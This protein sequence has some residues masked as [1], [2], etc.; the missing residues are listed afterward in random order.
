[1]RRP[2]H[3]RSGGFSLTEVVL[4]LGIVSFALVAVVGL[5]PVGLQAVKNSHDQAAAA[6]VLSSLADSLRRAQNSNGAYTFQFAGRTTAFSLNGA[7]NIVSWTNLTLEG[8][9]ES[10]IRNPK[11]LR[12]DLIFISPTNSTSPGRATV[13]VGWS[14]Q[15][16]RLHFDT[17]T[18]AWSNAD[19]SLTS[20]LVFLPGP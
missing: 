9:P 1:M 6:Q 19:G 7:T 15:S 2:D 20:G 17:A 18:L 14:A 5:L 8:D 4:A 12:A 13:S 16:P 11:R 3:H 10:T